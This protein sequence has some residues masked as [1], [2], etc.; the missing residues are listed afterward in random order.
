MSGLA[1]IAAASCLAWLWLALFRGGFWRCDMRLPLDPPA[2]TTWPEVVAV[3]PARDEAATIGRAV[4]SLRAQDYPGRLSV[5][6]VDDESRDA[7]AA[8]AR[9]ADAEVV[10]GAA[11][12]IGWVGKVW[13][14]SQGLAHAERTHP[15]ARWVLL[16][17]ADIEHDPGGVRRLVAMGEAA[18]LDLVSLMVRLR[19]QSAWERLLIPAFVFFFQKL[20]PFRWVADPRRS[21]A[22]AAGGCM[23]VRRS[24]LARAGGLAVIRDRLIDDCALAAALKAHGR[25]WLGLATRTYS[26]RPYPDLDDI[27]RM[28]VRTAYTQLH[29]SPSLLVGTLVGMFVLYSLPPLAVVVGAAVGD[30]PAMA[31]GAA[32]WILMAVLAVPT[33]RLYDQPAVWGLVLPAA[34]GLYAA[35]TLDSARRHLA[36]AGGGWKGRHYPRPGE[37]SE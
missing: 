24:A 26:L 14:Q 13:A 32:G 10:R 11:L 28:V 6:V 30:W 8:A 35:M 7:T 36:G 5:I 16:T 9:A 23:L 2:P 33:A 22:A 15:A 31:S 27:W 18:G 34:G 12:P 21:T 25:I 4:A 29:H 1:A 3:I 37:A 19:C 17:D 20:Y